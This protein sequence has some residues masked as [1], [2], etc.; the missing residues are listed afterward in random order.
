MATNHTAYIRDAQLEEVIK[1]ANLT[2]PD[3]YF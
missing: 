1:E 3:C 2:K